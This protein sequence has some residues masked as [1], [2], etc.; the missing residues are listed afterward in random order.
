MNIVL[1]LNAYYPYSHGGTEAYTHALALQLKELGHHVR[2]VI[3][4]F[5]SSTF[6]ENFYHEGI[7]VLTFSEPTI[8]SREVMLGLKPTQG[9]TN[10]ITLLERI[11]PD[12]VHFQ[13]IT[14]AGINMNV[15]HV[16]QAKLKGF[17]TILTMHLA[18]Y[19]CLSESMVYLQKDQCN[20]IMKAFKCS[21]CYLSSKQ[22]ASPLKKLI[23]ISSVSIASVLGYNAQLATNKIIGLGLH[24]HTR[25]THLNELSTYV[26]TIIPITHWY[27]KVLTSNGVPASKM[28]TILQGYIPSKNIGIKSNLKLAQ[29]QLKIV[30]LGRIT[31]QKGLKVLLE[32]LTNIS[33]DKYMVD[34]YGAYD[35]KDLYFNQC[36]QLIESKGLKVKFMGLL[37]RESV[38]NT[39]AQYD[40]L[41]LPSL[42]SEMSPLVIQEAFQAGIPVLGSN[43]PGISEQVTHQQNGILFKFNDP[44][45][46]HKELLDLIENPEIIAGL[47][48]KVLPPRPFSD[49]VDETINVY[50]KILS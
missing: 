37:N 14:G 24:L 7:E 12:I 11:N 2:V 44:N 45:S 50:K 49:V 19:T 32:A 17:K 31:E 13:M 30:F 43:V 47:K 28:V 42:F 18:H 46:L 10:F 20:G 8:N 6:P 39:L 23:S 36:K 4:R 41:A 48:N 26:D 15:N 34:L 9:I 22:G 1:V 3:P 27:K 25:K 35:D 29:K 38:E 16:K 40:I 21:Y 5:H 33:S